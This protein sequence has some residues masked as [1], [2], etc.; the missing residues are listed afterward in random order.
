VQVRVLERSRG[1]ERERVAAVVARDR[2][3]QGAN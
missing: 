1:D 3:E 2:F